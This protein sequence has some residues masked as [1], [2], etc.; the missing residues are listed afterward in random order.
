MD[1][2]KTNKALLEHSADTI[3][4]HKLLKNAL[5]AKVVD[6]LYYDK[7]KKIFFDKINELMLEEK[8]LDTSSILGTALKSKKSCLCTHFIGND[9]YDTAID[10]PFKIVL[11]NQ[12]IIPI[13]H[14]L[15]CK[16]ILRF[17]QLPTGFSQNDYRNLCILLPAFKRIFLY[18]KHSIYE[19]KSKEISKIDVKK[20]LKNLENAFDALSEYNSNPEIEK[21]INVGRK[22]KETL[23]IYLLENTAKKLDIA[24]KFKRLS[25]KKL[26]VRKE[27]KKIFANVLIADDVRIN[28]KILNAMLS[29]DAIIYQIRHAYDGIETMNIIDKCKE[30]EESIHILFLDHHM[31]GKTGLE[32]AK[33]LKKEAGEDTTIIIVSITNDPEVIASNGHLYD[34]HIP[35]PFN[36]KSI[37]SVMER[38]RIEHLS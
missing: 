31:P 25:N 34:Y 13:F 4:T 26:S 27:K 30:A 32:V 16:G 7:D 9:S 11:Y 2:T 8:Y 18:T 28:V 37:Q 23:E 15:E 5:G 17:S 1:F 36:K 12:I 14:N 6:I 3:A 33:T 19:S 35:K 20:T 24:D 38:I 29:E 21:L 10:N 22:N